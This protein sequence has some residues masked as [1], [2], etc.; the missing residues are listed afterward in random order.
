GRVARGAGAAGPV[1]LPSP[2]GPAGRRAGVAD[3]VDRPR[4]VEE[5]DVAAGDG[6]DLARARR[7]LADAR[8]PYELRHGRAS[9]TRSRER[10]GEQAASTAGIPLMRSSQPT[11]A[12]T[13]SRTGP[14]ASPTIQ[15]R[16]RNTAL[17]Q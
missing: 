4:R 9:G 3:R 13:W 6:H 2:E 15:L 12:G 5:R 11:T 1:A 16:W 14:S 17:T 8:R 7:D 10:Q